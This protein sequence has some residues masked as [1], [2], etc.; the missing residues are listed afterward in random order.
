VFSESGL[1]VALIEMTIAPKTW[2]ALGGPSKMALYPQN[3][4]LVVSTNRANHDA[5]A[6]VLKQLR[7]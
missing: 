2:E 4:S 6:A 3:A 1:P 5:L 7:R